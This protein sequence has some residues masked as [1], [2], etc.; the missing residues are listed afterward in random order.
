MHIYIHTYIHT[1]AQTHTYTCTHIL[2]PN[3]QGRGI[4][5]YN[6]F[7]GV[8]SLDVICMYVHIHTYTHI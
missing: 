1:Y 4:C 8:Y 6:Q 7:T 2:Q 5:I 3:S